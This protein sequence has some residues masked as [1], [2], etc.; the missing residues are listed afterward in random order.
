M[1]HLFSMG[2]INKILFSAVILGFVF[3]ACNSTRIPESSG[4]YKFELASKLSNDSQAISMVPLHAKIVKKTSITNGLNILCYPD[5]D[6][7]KNQALKTVNI[8]FTE[9]ANAKHVDPVHLYREKSKKKAYSEYRP[10]SF[11]FPGGLEFILVVLV[12][13]FVLPVL[14]AILLAL[15]TGSGI[16]A[17]CIVSI[18]I[19][20][21]LSIINS[22][23]L[24][25]KIMHWKSDSWIKLISVAAGLVFIA[26]AFIL[27]LIILHSW[28]IPLLLLAIF[29]LFT[30]FLVVAVHLLKSKVRPLQ[31]KTNS[32]T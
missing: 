2:H 8:S 1:I 21:G 12:L 11:K 19:S 18:L 13:L 26:S 15:L 22:G 20:F 25:F 9:S 3:N 23:L 7:Q 17:T 29:I 32:R 27:A 4:I 16:L 24:Y 5:Y 14:P 28:L 31:M 10:R 30:F 6:H